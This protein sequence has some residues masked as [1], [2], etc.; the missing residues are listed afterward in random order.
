MRYLNLAIIAG[1]AIALA[2]CNNNNAVNNVA[3]NE[4][5]A[6]MTVEAPANDASAMESTSNATETAPATTNESANTTGETSGGDTGGNN[7]ESNV[8]G[9]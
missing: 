4:L 6:N 1:T 7:V 5:D 9:M 3:S 2:A 8:S